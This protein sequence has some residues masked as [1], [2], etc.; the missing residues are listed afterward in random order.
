M[1]K[2][3]ANVSGAHAFKFFRAGG[4]D[5]VVLREAADIENLKHLDKKL[6]VALA[7]PV[8]GLSLDKKTLDLVDS[9]GDGRIRVPEILGAIEWCKS[10]FKKLD[11]LF[12]EGDAVALSEIDPKSEIGKAVLGGAKRILADTGKKVDKA[13]KLS[14]AEVEAAEKA[15]AE[16]RFNGDGVVPVDAAED[17]ALKTTMTE[18]LDVVGSVQDRSGK[19]GLDKPLVEK[20]FAEAEALIAWDDEG[21]ADGLKPLGDASAEAAAAFAV[22]RDKLDDYFTRCRVAQ[23][24]PRAADA[25]NAADIELSALTPKTLNASD[26]DLAKLPLARIEA[27]RALPL[28]IGLNPA[29]SGAMRMFSVKV[30]GPML[31]GERSTL[32]EADFMALEEKL[33]AYRGWAHKKPETSVEKLGADR[34]RAIVAAGTKASIEALIERDLAL[35]ADYAAVELVEKAVRFKRDFLTLLRNFV[36]FADF[37]GRKGA[38]FQAGTLFLDARACDLVVRVND[39]TKHAVLAA[40][41]KAYLAYCDCSRKGEAPMSIVAAFSAGDVDNL[42]VGRN[43]VFYDREGRDWDATITKIIE[44]PISIRQAFWMPYKRLVRLV[45]EQVAKRAAD[46]EK[47]STTAIDTAA[48][49]A[50]NADQ[51]KPVTAADITASPPAEPKKLDVGVIAAISVAVAGIGTFLAMVLSTFLGLG[52]W[53]P[54]GILAILLLISGPSM[55]IAWLKL[56]QRNIGPILDANGWAINGRMRI[57]VPFGGSLT[58]VAKLPEDATRALDDPFAEKPTPWA[59]YVVLLV[60]AGLAV[61]WLMG[62]LDRFLPEKARASHII[63]SPAPAPKSSAV[64]SAAPAAPPKAP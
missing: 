7:C 8:D 41:S 51:T 21:R 16:T 38:T 6:W 47:E 2:G 45:E 53:M 40:L 10:A 35:S 55:L 48:A 63:P 33:A 26:L 43:G 34:L 56:R 18:I 64:P 59:L 5:Q 27:G 15:I 14:L 24:D 60:I 25:L 50:A 23:Y 31:G 9:D 32:S 12:A 39:V 61:A 29:W 37:Y 36:S 54:V 44:N 57:N 17:E 62:K 3:T 42:M 11:V 49:S 20:F 19:P 30:V 46:K 4:V 13:E 52:F 58:K 22:V 1:T 28:S